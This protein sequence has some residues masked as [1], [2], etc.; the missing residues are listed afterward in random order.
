MDRLAQRYADPSFLLDGYIGT[1][2]F[3][4]FIRCFGEQR[5]DD[6]LWEYYLHKVFDKSFSDFRDDLAATQNNQNMTDSKIEATVK[7]SMDILGSFTPE[8]EGV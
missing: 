7:K 3:C 5:K 4:E 8:K 1:G 2:R 6:E